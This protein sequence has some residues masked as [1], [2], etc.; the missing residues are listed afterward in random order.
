MNKKRIAQYCC[1]ALVAAGVGLNIQNA[2]ADYGIAENSFSLV[3]VGG[4]NSGSNSN[5][6][7]NWN[8]NWN[9]NTDSNYTSGPNTGKTRETRTGSSLYVV[10]ISGS[11]ETTCNLKVGM[12]LSGGLDASLQGQVTAEYK[13]EYSIICYD[14]GSCPCTPEEWH[15][16][17]TSGCPKAEI[18]DKC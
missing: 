14:G 9:S 12:R 3:A 13:D 10:S 5:S 8:S 17:A 7:S 2:I 1:A 11:L 18:K 4:S 15:V 16:C 6:N